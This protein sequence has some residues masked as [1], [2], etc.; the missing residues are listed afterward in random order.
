MA[1]FPFRQSKSKRFER[2]VQPHLKAMFAFAYRL[3]GR[4]HDAE[5]LVQDVVVKLYPKLDELEAID[6]LRP[7]LNRVLYRQFV[8]S[9]RKRP[10]GREINAS[11]MDDTESATPYLD[12]LPSDVA[13]PITGLAQASNNVALTRALNQLTPDQRTLILLHDVDDWR[14]DDIAEVLEVA[15]G[16]VKSRL[17]RTRATLRKFLQAEL[18]PFEGEERE[19][20]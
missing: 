7:W 17:H 16:T 6:Q 3:T 20:Q 19:L 15:V 4:Q 8:D 10:A 13:D 1:L 5:D 12:T 2:L 14:Q 9:I 11:V 18:E